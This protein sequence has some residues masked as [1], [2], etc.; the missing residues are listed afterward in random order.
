VCLRDSTEALIALRDRCALRRGQ[1]VPSFPRA[2]FL[3][4]GPLP[5]LRSGQVFLD[6]AEHF[7]HNRSASV[8]TLRELFAFGLECR[9]RSLRP[10]FAFAGILSVGFVSRKT[11]TS[12]R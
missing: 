4:T 12:A 2:P 8:A 7:L 10:A 9:S 5:P 6:E 11:A 3:A 1:D